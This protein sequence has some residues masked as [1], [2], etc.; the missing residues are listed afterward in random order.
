MRPLSGPIHRS[1][2]LTWWVDEVLSILLLLFDLLFK[3]LL[4][5]LFLL[6][7]EG[8]LD[9]V[10]HVLIDVGLELHVLIFTKQVSGCVK[11]HMV[12]R[13]CPALVKD[14]VYYINCTIGSVLRFLVLVGM[15]VREEGPDSGLPLFFSLLTIL[16]KYLY[17]EDYLIWILQFFFS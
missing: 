3:F 9:L 5:L 6:P 14:L 11:L 2:A 17:N 12:F 16:I 13:T 15:E 4:L 10:H 8:L 7:V 1:L